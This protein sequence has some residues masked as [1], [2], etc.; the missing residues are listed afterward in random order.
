M[1]MV[2]VSCF[3]HMSHFSVTGSGSF[4]A[5]VTTSM[6]VYSW[7]A[8]IVYH[9]PIYTFIWYSF[10]FILYIGTVQKNMSQ[11]LQNLCLQLVTM[12]IS[13]MCMLPINYF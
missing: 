11:K 4:E 5:C 10:L 13:T 6:R 7:H 9:R 2:D 8:V 12:F 3:T 1:V